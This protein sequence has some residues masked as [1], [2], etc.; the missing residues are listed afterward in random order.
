MDDVTLPTPGCPVQEET[1]PTMRITDEERQWALEIKRAVEGSD[2]IKN[3][4]DMVYAHHAIVARGNLEQAL[5]S[6]ERIQLFREHYKVDHS[7]E[8]GVQFLQALMDQQPGFLLNI[9]IDLDR[10]E[11]INA[12]DCGPYDPKAAFGTTGVHDNWRVFCCGAYYVK[13]ASQPNFAVIRNGLLELVDFG[14]FS[15]A[16]FSPETSIRFMDEWMRYYPMKM[17]GLLMYNT[18]SVANMILS[19]TKPLMSQSQKNALQ[20][21]C[22]VMEQDGSCNPNRRLK[23]FYLQPTPEFAQEFLLERARILLTTRQYHEASFR[24]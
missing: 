8:Q 12:F 13:F 7:V 10:Q 19:L 6:I 4:N 20:L 24:L 2:E 16:N 17:S 14:D 9:D 3:L 11:A 21:G 22:Q 15:W 1:D 18:G 5:Q 23:E